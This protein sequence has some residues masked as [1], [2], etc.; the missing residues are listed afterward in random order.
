MSSGA[1]TREYRVFAGCEVQ[2]AAKDKPPAPVILRKVLRSTL[3]R[4]PRTEQLNGYDFH[5]LRIVIFLT[6]SDVSCKGKTYAT[7]ATKKATTH[8]DATA[9]D[10][11]V[12]TTGN[13]WL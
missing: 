6:I 7:H 12:E 3:Q 9:M 13:L 4:A 8:H 2:P 11:P 5:G 10:G 1:W